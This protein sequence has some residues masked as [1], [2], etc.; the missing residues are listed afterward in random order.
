MARPIVLRTSDD[1]DVVGQLRSDGSSSASRERNA[2][3]VVAKIRIVGAWVRG[4]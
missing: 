2:V 1:Q 4:R 3:V